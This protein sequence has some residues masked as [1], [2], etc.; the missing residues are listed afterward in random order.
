[1]SQGTL[2][3]T[4]IVQLLLRDAVG[5]LSERVRAEVLA[6]AVSVERN[7]REQ[8]QRVEPGAYL[9]AA[10]GC[11][12]AEAQEFFD[13]EVVDRFQQTVHDEQWDTTWPAC[14]RHPNHPLWYRAEEQAWYC[15][16][17]DA[18]L[19]PLGGLTNLRAPAQAG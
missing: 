17:D 19:A 18:A 16:A 4:R 2:D 14:P 12:L 10:A 15:P 11:S 3:S 6:T 9:D 13:R 5:T 8:M 1:M 7:A